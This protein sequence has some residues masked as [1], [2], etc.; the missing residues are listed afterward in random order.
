M[1]NVIFTSLQPFAIGMFDQS[2]KA[3][4]R[5]NNPELY[6]GSQKSDQFSSK[7]FWKWIFLSVI[8]SLVIFFIPLGIYKY[9]QVW[10]NGRDGDYLVIG[11]NDSIPSGWKNTFISWWHTLSQN[12]KKHSI[13]LLGPFVLKKG[14]NRGMKCQFD[15]LEKN[16]NGGPFY[17]ENF[18]IS[19]FT[20]VSSANFLGYKNSKHEI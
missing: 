12:H 8:H 20:Q 6:K 11:K 19:D 10:S 3:D 16:S 17:V 14:P 7:V 5:L 9:G 15:I 18:F 13:A 1:Y 4:T 2:C